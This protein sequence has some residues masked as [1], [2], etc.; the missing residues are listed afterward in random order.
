MPGIR[1]SLRVPIAPAWACLCILLIGGGCAAVGQRSVVRVPLQQAAPPHLSEGADTRSV[2]S[3]VA[4]AVVNKLGLPLSSPLNA[5]LYSTEEAFELGLVTDA[6]IE[7]WF[8][9]DQARFAWGVGSYYGIFLREDKLATAPLLT[10]VG[11]IAHE[12]MHV[13]QY[14]LAGGRRGTSD[15]WLREGMA[16]WA[17]FR[18]LEHFGL[19]SYAESKR[20]LLQ[21]VRRAGSIDKFPSLGSLGGNRE[22]TT[23]QNQSGRTATYVQAFLA[24]DLLLE[25]RGSDAV[26][27]YFRRFGRLNDRA[28]NFQAAFGLPVG[29]FADE[30]RAWL[31][32]ALRN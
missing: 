28:E 5:Y 13:S 32:D 7:T 14:E 19:R 25:R 31:S 17:R 8:A 22:W 26:L 4:W 18:V 30:F 15:Q 1:R 21:E 27:D 11:L 3:S 9:K 29:Q 24:F 23:T 6:R 10:R 20:R 16:E 12:L 2:L